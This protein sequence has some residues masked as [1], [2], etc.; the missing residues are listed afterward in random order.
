MTVSTELAGSDERLLVAAASGQ[1][2]VAGAEEGVGTRVDERE[3]GQGAGQPRVA[4]GAALAHGLTGRLVDLRAELG[5]R[6]QMR[7]RGE[8]VM[9]TPI[10]AISSAAATVL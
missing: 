10:S 1:A 7:G 9:S 4:L 8:R 6:H 3:A 5:P 2:P